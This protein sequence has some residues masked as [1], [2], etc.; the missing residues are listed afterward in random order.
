MYFWT[1]GLLNTWLDKCLKSPISEDASTSNMGNGPKHCWRLDY[2]TFT[3]FIDPC[4]S[5]LGLKSVSERYPK[6]YDCFLTHSLPIINILFLREAIYCNIFRCNYLRN[7][8][9]FR[10]FFLHFLNLEPISNIFKKVGTHIADVILTLR[11]KWLDKCLRSP[12]SDYP[13]KSNMVNGPKRCSKLNDSTFTI[14]IDPC[15][16]HSVWKASLIDMEN[17]RTFC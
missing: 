8:N 15:E 11:K 6:S 13:R 14:F 1:Y 3:I 17:L 7:E 10:I 16:G 2:S 4:E 5:N 12:V 9:Y